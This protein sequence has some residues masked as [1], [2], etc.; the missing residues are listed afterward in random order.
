MMPRLIKSNLCIVLVMLAACSSDHGGQEQP[1]SDLPLSEAQEVYA[2]YCSGCH[3]LSQPSIHSAAEWPAIVARMQ[4]RRT[5]K[6][7]S[8][9]PDQQI[10][11][12][13]DYLQQHAEPSQ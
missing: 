1:L 7:F 13:I 11:Q 4:Q 8:R 9:I 3:A 10:E 6:G 5:S 12:I 2:E